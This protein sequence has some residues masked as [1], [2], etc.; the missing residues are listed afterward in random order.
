MCKHK[1]SRRG[2]HWTPALMKLFVLCV[3]YDVMKIVDSTVAANSVRQSFWLQNQNE[4]THNLFF[5]KNYNVKLKLAFIQLVLANEC[6]ALRSCRQSDIVKTTT[7][8]ICFML[9]F[10]Y[11]CECLALHSCRQSDIVKTTT[12]EIC[13]VLILP[14]AYECLALCSCRRFQQCKTYYARA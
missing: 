11:A 7:P 1:T 13:F 8:E 5:S 4:Q 10:P 14:Y 12:P 3:C 2:V 6:L 9:I